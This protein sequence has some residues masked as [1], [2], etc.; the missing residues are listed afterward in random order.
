MLNQLA[1]SLSPHEDRGHKFTSVPFVH[2][3]VSQLAMRAAE[4]RR[5]Q[6]NNFITENVKDDE[7]KEAL[8][9]VLR[10]LIHVLTVDID[11]KYG[12]DRLIPDLLFSLRFQRSDM[13][14]DSGKEIQNEY[15]DINKEVVKILREL[16]RRI[17]RELKT[18]LE[19]AKLFQEE[20]IQVNQIINILAEHTSGLPEQ[21]DLILTLT[22]DSLNENFGL[23]YVGKH[24]KVVLQVMMASARFCT[25]GNNKGGWFI[26]SYE[27]LAEMMNEVWEHKYTA[28]NAERH[29]K[30]LEN[31]LNNC[32]NNSLGIVFRH[33]RHGDNAPRV[34]VKFDP[35][36]DKEFQ[37]SDHLRLSGLGIKQRV[38]VLCIQGHIGEAINATGLRRGSVLVPLSALG[39][40][41]TGANGSGPVQN[42]TAVVRIVNRL[43]A[44]LN[45][46]GPLSFKISGAD[47]VVDYNLQ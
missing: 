39:Q 24:Q 7:Q 2:D 28:K 15:L 9:I 45:G 29:I 27:E 6:V 3:K 40:A 33:A 35:V 31:K 30:D 10:W 26:M 1:F 42:R 20:T 34:A 23:G 25:V 43:A 46:S 14:T 18:L 36:V 4:L 12:S 13:Y 19:L 16:V 41:F 17:G 32:P 5:N 11:A 44:R 22:Q 38:V 47:V 37:L 21:K 8:L